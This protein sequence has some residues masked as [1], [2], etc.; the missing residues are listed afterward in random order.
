VRVNRVKQLL[1]E[2]KPALGTWLVSG[3]SVAAEQLAHAGFDWLNIDQEHAA[4]DA[5]LTAFIL[6]AISTTETVPLVRVPWNDPAYIKRALDA[7]AFGVVVP[8]VNSGEEARAAVQAA[9][10]PPLGRRSIG[11]I[12]TRLYGGADYFEKANDE[13]LVILQIEHADAVRNCEAILSTPGVDGYMVG[14]NDLCASMGIPSSY[15]P[16]APEFEAALDT[17]LQVAKRL[18]VA[19]GIHVSSGA[20]AQRRIAQGYQFISIQSDVN[21]VAAAARSA[22]AEARAG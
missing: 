7:A 15:D 16:D 19:A 6:Q 5:T 12:R 2:G 8:M 21:F 1:R 17:V 11:G 4:I 20:V 9:K 13:L 14:P 22:L 18:G 3:S 10:Y